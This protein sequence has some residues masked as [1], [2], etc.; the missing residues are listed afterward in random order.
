MLN[1]KKDLQ[2]FFILKSTSNHHQ[3]RQTCVSASAA[4]WKSNFSGSNV[5]PRC[6]CINDT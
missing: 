2:I 3:Q 6:D 4:D 5:I 1:K